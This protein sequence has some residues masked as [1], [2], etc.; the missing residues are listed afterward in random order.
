MK[1][2]LCDSNQQCTE[3]KRVSLST[4][5]AEI[6]HRDDYSDEKQKETFSL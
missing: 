3:Q 1:T 6:K 5:E 2:S 4:K